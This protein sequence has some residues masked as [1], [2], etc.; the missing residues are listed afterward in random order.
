M[1]ATTSTQAAPLDTAMEIWRDQ[2]I[3]LAHQTVI[4]AYSDNY[5]NGYDAAIVVN[6]LDDIRVRDTLLYDISSIGEDRASCIMGIFALVGPMFPKDYCAPAATFY[7]ILTGMNGDLETAM[8]FAK[9]AIEID[10]NYSLA[11]IQ[12]GMLRAFGADYPSNARDTFARLSRSDCR[13]G[14]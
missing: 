9:G 3:D 1:T 12:Y 5:I 13:Y 8:Q 7:S 14:R 10:S 2:M 4:T 6:A 11:V